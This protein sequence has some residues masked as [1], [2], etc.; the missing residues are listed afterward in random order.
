MRV[1]RALLAVFSSSSSSSS[2]NSSSNSNSSSSSSSNS[3]SS[4]SS[5]SHGG[6]GGGGGGSVCRVTQRIQYIAIYT[7]GSGTGSMRSHACDIP[8]SLQIREHG[9]P[10]KTVFLVRPTS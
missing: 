1:C 8:D 2:S 3:S 5:S 7:K 4:S 6:G 10:L 9:D